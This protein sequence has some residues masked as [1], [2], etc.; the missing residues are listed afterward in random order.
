MYRQREIDKEREQVRWGYMYL[1][2]YGRLPQPEE[3]RSGWLAVCY[4]SVACS[5]SGL[6]A[7][8]LAS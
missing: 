8:W 1:S 2:I 5:L 3:A 7:G 6:Q 4:S